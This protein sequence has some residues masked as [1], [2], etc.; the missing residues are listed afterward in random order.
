[1]DAIFGPLLV[2]I[3]A[4]LAG[5]L[6]AAG[7]RPLVPA[8]VGEILAGVV[9]GRSGLGLIDAGTSDNQLIH[10]LG[11]GMLMLVAGTRVDLR[12]PGL[13]SGAR[14]GAMAVAIVALLAVPAGLAIGAVLAPAS[15]PILF[16]VLL[17]GSSAAV[18]FPVFEE[19]GLLGP[20][21]GL[22]LAWI[23]LAD[24]LSVIAMPLTLVGAAKVPAA[25]AG[26]A[27][28]VLLI[29]LLFVAG[30]RLGGW[31]RA[32]VVRDRSRSRGWALQLRLALLMLVVLSAIAT[33]MGGSTLVAG[34]GTGMLIA[35]LG[36]PTRLDLQ[37][38]GIAEGFFVPAFFVLLGAELDLH[39]LASDPP[40]MGLAVAMATAAIAIHLVASRAVAGDRALGFGLAASAQLGL[41]AAAASLGMAS[42][43][44]SPSIAAGLV[45]AGLLTVVPASLG[46]RRL[47]DT[48]GDGAAGGAGAT[49]TTAGGA[50]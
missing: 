15:P 50:A 28:I 34:F 38:S 37:L 16:V 19:R 14:A 49:S 29:G 43:L 21:V 30:E 18:A 48:L 39:A 32:L 11:F 45:L 40:A 12:A 44:V 47:A 24:A 1:M 17:A 35:R 9:I 41:P 2:L 22:L 10:A 20:S 13:R 3:V 4:G 31:S 33:G 6:I 23:A 27:I 42:G 25:I 36:E 5:P 8:V 26:D 46:T 7:R